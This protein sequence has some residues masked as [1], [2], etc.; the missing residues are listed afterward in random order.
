MT[1]TQGGGFVVDKTLSFLDV[2]F[3]KTLSFLYQNFIS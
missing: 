1:I 2:F 3:G